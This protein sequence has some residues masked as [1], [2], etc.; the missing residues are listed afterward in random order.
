MPKAQAA[1]PLA[2]ELTK[3]RAEHGTVEW[4]QVSADDLREL[5]AGRVPDIIQRNAQWAC[6]PVEVMLTRK[7][8]KT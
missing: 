8:R 3:R 4:L 7:G 5:A 2:E 1:L 6:E